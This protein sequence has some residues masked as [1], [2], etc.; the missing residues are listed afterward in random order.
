MKERKEIK[1]GEYVVITETN[2]DFNYEVK[3]YGKLITI[4]TDRRYGEVKVI[5]KRSVVRSGEHNRDA[6]TF[7]PK[8]FDT[9]SIRLMELNEMPTWTKICWFFRNVVFP[10]RYG[11]TFKPATF[12]KKPEEEKDSENVILA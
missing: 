12:V 2:P 1:L 10:L 3:H 9:I 11:T 7:S 4:D 8:N 6:F 5:I